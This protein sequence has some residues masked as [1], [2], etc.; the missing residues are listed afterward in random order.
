MKAISYDK[1]NDIEAKLRSGVSYRDI[2]RTVNVSV[3]TVSNIAKA[4]GIESSNK[5]GRPT[6]I[7]T[8]LGRL[9]LR[10]FLLGTFQTAVDAEKA[11]RGQ[12]HKIS[13]ETIRRFLKSNKFDSKIKKAASR[14]PPSG[15]R[16]VSLGQKNTVP[17]RLKTGKRLYL[18]TKRR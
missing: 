14:L 15:R 1:K 17:G 11:L 10:S 5:P 3:V 9:I 18:A 8:S 13:A 2:S 4:M 6:A 7:S 12:G 16:I